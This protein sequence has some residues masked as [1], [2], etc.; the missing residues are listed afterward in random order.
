MSTALVDALQVISKEAIEQFGE[1]RQL[2]RC[3]MI[4]FH[5]VANLADATERFA[6]ASLTKEEYWQLLRNFSGMMKYYGIAKVSDG[7]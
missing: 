1:V 4:D 2:G 6:L 7:R 5:C 3:N